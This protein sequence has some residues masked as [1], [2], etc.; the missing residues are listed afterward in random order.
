MR[1]GRVLAD[2]AVLLADG[3]QSIIDLAAAIP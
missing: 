1:R 2:L 3:D